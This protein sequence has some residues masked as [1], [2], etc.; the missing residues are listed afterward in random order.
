M[1]TKLII[2]NILIVLMFVVL[3]T[4]CDIFS[5]AIDDVVV[6]SASLDEKFDENGI[7]YLNIV[8][9]DINGALSDIRSIDAK[10]TYLDASYTEVEEDLDVD[11][12]D[13]VVAESSSLPWSIAIDIDSSGSMS[14]NDSEYVRKDAS[15]L[16]VENILSY[17]STS[18]FNIYDFGAGSTTGFSYS[19]QL[20]SDWTSDVTTIDAAIDEVVASGGTPLFESIYEILQAFVVEK[21]ASSYQRAMLVLSDGSPDSYTNRTTV[22]EYAVSNTIPINTVYLGDSD[23][24]AATMRELAE[25]TGGI[26]ASA[27]DADALEDAF[28]G[29]SLGT[30]EGYLVYTLTFADPDE[31]YGSTV[32]IEL[33]I[34]AKDYSDV[35]ELTLNL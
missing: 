28:V 16:F 27:D 29:L 25:N 15:K 20:T 13:T 24:T 30:N 3:I 14:S 32:S 7:V 8:P 2:T 9:I 10:A 21:A 33:E 31:I 5:A 4:G 35:K 6:L 23:Y 17:D 34:V 12:E 26:Y 22:Y 18:E 11:K 19:R 1:K